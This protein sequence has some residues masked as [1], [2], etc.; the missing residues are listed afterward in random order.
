MSR[1]SIIDIVKMK[2]KKDIKGLCKI[3]SS[4]DDLWFNET[5]LA[6]ASIG[7]QAMNPIYASIKKKTYEDWGRSF[8]VL[9]FMG[10]PAVEE[11]I[12]ILNYSGNDSVIRL[13]AVQALGFIGDPRAAESFL[14]IIEDPDPYHDFLI[15]SQAI[16]TIGNLIGLEAQTLL[17]DQLEDNTFQTQAISALGKIGDATAVEPLLKILDYASIQTE[18]EVI[19]ALGNIGSRLKDQSRETILSNLVALL[20]NKNLYI[21]S[22]A[23]LALGEIPDNMAGAPLLDALRDD[24]AFV[25]SAAAWGLRNTFNFAKELFLT[26]ALDDSDTNVR[27][28]AAE[29]LGLS[30]NT[31]VVESLIRHFNDCESEVRAK[32]AL[33]LGILQD[34]Q[35]L[36]P[37]IS[38]LKDPKPDVRSNVVIALQLLN[39]IQSV[40]PL[41]ETLNRDKDR[42]VRVKAAAALGKISGPSSIEALINTLAN[43]DIFIC[44]H[45]IQALGQCGDKQA[46]QAL[47]AAIAKNPALSELI[48]AL[49]DIEGRDL[50]KSS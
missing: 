31:S 35:A 49:A 42:L 34:K 23:A 9:K 37:L 13:Y 1:N 3:F 43:K 2:S 11:L 28:N 21:R 10:T 39:D 33:S 22:Y 36:Q 16:A 48:E 38:R 45:A 14:K 25:R 8:L 41:I 47:E 44:F 17:I 7:V 4:K 29:T 50:K 5:C 46:I 27:L 12:K 32:I 15:K 20:K 19:K 26:N 30:G 18:T 24:Q 6:L 40:Q